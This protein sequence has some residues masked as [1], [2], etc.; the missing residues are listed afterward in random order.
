MFVQPTLA[1]LID[2]ADRDLYRN[3]WVRA[4]PNER[5][6]LYPYRAPA[7]GAAARKPFDAR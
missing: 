1:Q 7:A 3:K 4:H 2:T 6:E 5:A